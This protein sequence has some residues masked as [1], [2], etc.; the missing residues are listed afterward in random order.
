[1]IYHNTFESQVQFPGKNSK[2]MIKYLI[3]L[4]IPFFIGCNHRAPQQPPNVV[5]FLA[6]DLGYNDVSGYRK[7]HPAHSDTPPTTNTPNIDNLIAQGMSFTDFYCGAAVCSPS[8]SALMTG[9]NATRVGIYN[10]IPPN[11]PM[12][13]RS[14]EVTIAE[15]LK[16]AGYNT[17]HFGKWHLTSE[18]PDQPHPN[19][20]G[21]DFSVY[22]Y[23]NANPS[24]HN[25]NNYFKNGEP[26][27][28]LE[29]YA[30]QLVIDE[31][32]DWLEGIDK[33]ADPFYLNVWFN[34][35]HL[36]VAA[37][38]ELT[39]KHPYNK[40]YYGAIENL[41]LAMGRMLE[42]LEENGLSDNTIILFTSDNGS[43]WDHSNDPLRGEKCFNYEGGIRVPFVARWPGKIPSGKINDLPG[44][45][46]DVLPSIAAMTGAPLPDRKLDGV[47]LASVFK[48]KEEVIE[49]EEPLFFYRYFHDP[50]CML[51]DGDWC[52]LGYQNLIPKAESLNEGALANIK[53]GPGEPPGSQWRFQA[54]HMEFIKDQ[55]PDKFEL[56]NLKE[57][58]EQEHNLADQ[59]P[60]RVAAMK[61]RMLELKAEMVADGG[62][63]FE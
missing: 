62:N 16:G 49:R 34:E 39:Q 1:M 15:V 35:P 59:Y 46:T 41:D 7:M 25:P 58:K 24:H 26:M 13:M 28:E 27:G 45:F 5:I 31:A 63:W 51:R 11:S 48:G 37:P 61:Q 53:P 18:G 33:E 3:F 36:K 38:D 14:E 6:D 60:A 47:S 21:F 4:V 29:G 20:Q 19:D 42:Y 54:G 22:A 9:R 23:N 55:V 32:I 57:D 12:H 44:S 50:I 40:E 30:C 52:L 43:R 10:W 8:R 2:H 56:Y 17:G